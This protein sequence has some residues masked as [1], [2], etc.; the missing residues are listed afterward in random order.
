MKALNFLE[1]KTLVDTL[2]PALERAQL[3]DVYCNER[4]LVLGFRHRGQSYFLI[5]DLLMSAPCVLLFEGRS[6]WKKQAKPKPM[7]LFLKSHFEDLYF[8]KAELLE[9][10]GRVLLFQFTGKDKVAE[11]E[12]HL[13]PKQVN[14][15][16]RAEGKILSWNKPKD[17]LAVSKTDDFQEVRSYGVIH[18]QWVQSQEDSHKSKLQTDPRVAWETQRDRDLTKKRKALSEIE[19]QLSGDEAERWRDLGLFLKN[20]LSAQVDTSFMEQLKSLP[21]ALKFDTQLSIYENMERAFS[22]AKQVEAKKQGTLDRKEVLIKEI[23]ALERAVFKPHAHLSKPKKDL[24]QGADAKGRKLQ[25][26]DGAVAYLGKS[27]ADNLAIL[28]SAKAWDLWF[29]L[30]DY[31]GAHAVIHRN[32]DQKISEA[33][34]LKVAKW[35]AQ[36]SSSARSLQKGSR[37]S[38]VIVECRYVRPIKGDKAGKVTYTHA[39]FFD[40]QI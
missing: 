1:V 28:R 15:V 23:E 37:L 3:Q 14:A 26:E 12:V 21:L 39:K 20:Q 9:Q 38:V 18:D 30:R 33:D 32:K 2:G 13:I 29:H 25:I 5:L 27:A 35:V 34:L 6:P 24:M 22:K 11:L 7:T 4:G 17:L 40:V 19:L 10:K 31:P 8:S 36:E 16:A